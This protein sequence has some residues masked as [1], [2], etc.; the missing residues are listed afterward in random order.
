M[1]ELADLVADI[2]VCRACRLADNRTHV[3]PGEGA[4][5]AAL[6]VV[7]E[8]PGAREDELGRPFVGRSG[9]L[10]D[11]LLAEE[12]GLDR[13]GCY[14]AN[15]VKCRP[16]GNRTPKPDEVEACRGF[17]VRQLALVDPL[18]VVA[19]GQTAAAW[20]LGPGARVGALRG[21]VLDHEGR[22]LVVTYHP[23]AALRG[24]ASVVAALRSDLARAGVALT[25]RGR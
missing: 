24:G 1:R 8:G 14:I 5:P 6:M 2:E 12:L 18:V 25:E 20:F 16:P 11:R 3:V 21:R 22:A 10:L 19:L 17:L 9:E 23:S 13:R 4:V 15:V 7:G